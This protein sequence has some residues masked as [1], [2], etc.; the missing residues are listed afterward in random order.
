MLI[1]VLVAILIF[2]IAALGLVA[3]LANAMQIS[4]DGENRERAAM[5]ASSITSEMWYTKTVNIPA[6]DITTWQ[7]TLSTTTNPQYG[8]PGGTGSVDTSG[9]TA[10]VSVSWMPPH[11]TLHTYQ[12]IVQIP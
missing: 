1:E 10:F 8:L 7:G 6:A 11:G 9:N 12:T 2:A 5:L 3:L 4:I